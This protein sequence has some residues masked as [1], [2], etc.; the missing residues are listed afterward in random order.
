MAFTDALS[1]TPA[2]KKP[3]AAVE[4]ETELSGELDESTGNIK[5]D[6]ADLDAV[7]ARL[8]EVRI[9]QRALKKEEDRLKVLVLSHEHAK[10]GYSNEFIQIVSMDNLETTPELLEALITTKKLNEAFNMSISIP[11]IRDLAEKHKVI[12]KAYQNSLFEGRKIKTL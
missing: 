5:L 3:T 7:S 11:K 1:D 4:I 12:A 8:R 10:I 6:T 2:R 9:K